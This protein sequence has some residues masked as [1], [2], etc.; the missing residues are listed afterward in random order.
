MLELKESV[1]GAKASIDI[2]MDGRQ[3]AF[4][5]D[6]IMALISLGYGRPVAENAVK[7][8]VKKLNSVD[9]IE[10]LVREALK[11]KT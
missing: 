10:V 9:N 7:E 5:D 8:A 11:F 4:A 1:K 3:R 2:E 6:A